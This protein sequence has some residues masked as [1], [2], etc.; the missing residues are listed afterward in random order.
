VATEGVMKSSAA[1]N[2]RAN[3][4]EI[5]D[6]STDKDGNFVKEKY[7]PNARPLVRELPGMVDAQIFNY[8]AARPSLKADAPAKQELQ[9]EIL[10]RLFTPSKKTN[11][12]D[13]NGFDGR[14]TL[15]GYLNG[16]I[17]YRM[18]DAFEQNPT[19]I[20]DYSQ[21]Q[22]DEA[23]TALEQELADELTSMQDKE[24]DTPRNKT[25]V[26]KI[27]KIAD[28]VND[29]KD[30]VKVEKGDTFKEVTDKYAGKVAEEIFDVP[31]KKI[32][33]PAKNL[34]Y[35]KKIVDGIPEASEAGN[36]QNFYA[37]GDSMGKLLKTLPEYNVTSDD[38]DINELGENIDVSRNVSG[39]GLGLKNKLIEFFYDPVMTKDGKHKRSTG[40][41]SQ[42]K[43]YKLKPEFAK[44]DQAAIDKAKEAAGITPRGEL[45]NYDRNT[46]QFL[47]GLAYF[48]GQQAALS[49]AQ[50][51]LT[52]QAAENKL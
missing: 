8:F 47:K 35:A 27:G 40:K 51:N 17:K 28:K 23:R 15:Y 22:I 52:E 3:L 19:I 16:R 43:L 44:G 45:N 11:R 9:A 4:K 14:G 34:T 46:G 1:D 41:T 31:S 5:Q 33:D 12:S 18:L 7:D 49:A 42:V 25:N 21:K 20:P 26:L 2:A 30:I 6:D 10:A 32:T 38:A 50:R 29:I 36:I 37:T 24:L 48:Q 13:M 39:R